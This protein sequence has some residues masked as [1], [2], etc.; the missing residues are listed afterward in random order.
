VARRR[1]P[2]APRAAFGREIAAVELARRVGRE[3]EVADGRAVGA[4]RD[5][6]LDLVEEPRLLAR[7]AEALEH[8]L[9][10]AADGSRYER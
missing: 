9:L 5:V 7:R 3:I 10:L 1:A 6:R 4:L 2:V 8:A